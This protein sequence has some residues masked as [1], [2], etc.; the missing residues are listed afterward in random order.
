MT[1]LIAV[2]DIM[3][4]RGMLAAA[5]RL[6]ADVWP[7]ELASLIGSEL[8]TGNLECVLAS[9]GEANP[10]A[11]SPFRTDPKIARPIVEGFNVLNLANNH[12]NDYGDA[13]IVNTMQA[14]DSWGVGYVGVGPDPSSAYRPAIIDGESTSVAILGAT[15]VANI[16][17]GATDFYIAQP[18]DRFVAQVSYLKSQGM[19]VVVHLHGGL[20]DTRHPSPAMVRLHSRLRDA[21]ADIV[22]G[23]H[24]HIIQPWLQDDTGVSFF[25]LGDCVFDKLERPRDS[26]LVAV[27]QRTDAG[28]LHA[29]TRFL[30]RENDLSLRFATRGEAVHLDGELDTARS[31]ILDGDLAEWYRSE[32]QVSDRSLQTLL[33][34]NWRAGG[35]KGI[36]LRLQRKGLRGAV[37]LVLA[38]AKSLVR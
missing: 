2:G 1:T 29:Q 23:H 9:S 16:V 24:P 8:S 22:L 19:L 17:S 25:S 35:L 34:E 31:H 37:S 6:G 13:G 7:A 18:D 11:H 33:R 32:L 5:V 20:G 21:G 10:Y 36:L 3:L 26:S 12:V 4:S 30:C 14:L 38:R 27:L 28:R 15:T